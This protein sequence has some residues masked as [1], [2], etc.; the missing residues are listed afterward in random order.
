MRLTD[1]NHVLGALNKIVLL[2][3]F[4]CNVHIA[5]SIF[6]SGKEY[7]YSYDAFSS[8]GVL[9]PSRASSSWGFNGKLK[10]QSEQNVVTMQLES[11]RMNVWNGK[12]DDQGESQYVPEDVTDLL[13]PFQLVYKNGFIEN[14]STEAVSPWSTNIKRSI[15]GILQLDLS[16][17]QKETAFHSNE[18]NHY[19]QCNI[20]Y[21]ANSEEENEL[22]IRKFFD[23]RICIGHPNYFWSNVPKILCPNGD[24]NPL[25]K[26]SE[27]LYKVKVNG[28]INEI[29]F[30]NATGGIYLQPF[31]SFGEAQFH[32]TRQIFKLISVKDTVD[33][34]PVKDL[35]YKV[36]QHELP[37]IDLTQGRGTPDKSIVI[38]SIG[39]L[40]DRLSQRLE[41]PGLDTETD[42]LHNTTIS[43]LLYYLGMLDIVD[44]RNSYTRISGTSYKEET[45]RNMFL[46]ALPQVGTKEAALFILE[47]IQDK[48]VSDMSAIQLLTQLPF[49]IRKPDVQLLVNLQ[50]FLNLPEKISMEVQNTAILA[51]G[52]LIYKTCLLY[53]PYEMLDDY[54]RLYLDKFTETKEY[55]K[56][57]I[58]LEGLANIQLGRVVEFLE[59]IA[60]GSN[61]E[62]RHFRV[63]AAW[64]SLPTAP[65]RPDVIY[66]VYWPILVNRTEH[67]E[68]RIAAL[69]LLIV[70]NPTPSRLITLYWYMQSEPS[71]HLYNYFYTILKSMVHTTH[72]C[73]V[74]I[75]VI[76]AQFTRVLRPPGNKYLITGN[77]LFDYQDTYRKFGAMI[78]GIVIANPLTNIPEVLYV[79]VNT[80]GSG[81]N[82]NHVSLYIKAEGLLHSLSTHQDGPTQVKDILKQ[83]KVDPRQTGPVH[84]EIIARIQE[85]TVLCLHLNETNLIKGFK[86]LSSLPDNVYHIYQNMEFHVNQQRINV[87]LI[88]ESVQVTDLGANVRFAI[89]ATSLFSMRGN[90]TRVSLGRNN[91]IILRT[92]IHK[93]EVIES[94][95]PLIDTWHTAERAYSIHGYLPINITLG[96]EQRPFISYNTPKEHLKMGI[97]AHARTSTNIKGLAIKSK[98]NQICPTCP[99]LYIV[100]KSPEYKSQTVDL[101]QAELAELGG[102]MY[103]KLFDCESVISREKLIRDVL[104][105]HRA[106]YPIWPFLEFAFTALHFLDYCT[107]VPPKGSC[108]VAAYISTLDAQR[109]QVKLEYNKSP[110][111]HLLSLTRRNAES[112]Q[113]LQQWNVAALY[114]ITSWLSDVIKIK[115]TKLV[116]GQEILKF[117]LEAE[118]E[119]PWTWDFLSTKPSD[120][121]RISLNAIW[122]YSDTAKGKCNGSSITLNLL[123]EIS[124][125][126][127]QDSKKVQWP[128]EECRK[129]SEGKRFT[130]YT[131]ACYETSRELSTLRKYQ[132]I[133]QHENVPEQ[134]IRLAWKLRA[135]YDLIGGNSS[136][137]P[138]SK[139][140]VLTATFPNQLDTGELSLNNDAVAIEY[141]YNIIDYFLTRTRIHKYMD[142]SVL[143]AFFG[144]CIVTP[145]YIRSIHNVTYSFHNKREVLLFGQCYHENPKYALTAQNDLYGVN[146]NIYDEI[147]TVRIVPNQTGGTLYNK[148]MY[149]SIPQSFMF[150]SLGTKRVRLDSSTMD[151]IVPNLYLYMHWTQEQILLFFPTYLLEFSCGLCALQT[152][153]TDNLYEKV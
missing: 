108:G 44:L 73:Y 49:H 26:S 34:I 48:K 11:L 141:N 57:M 12:I 101:F 116:P 91:H 133:A 58:W 2:F 27:R 20:E 25:M 119:M 86:Y 142:M 92:S 117:C 129:Q 83:F 82:I 97:T 54:V 77:Y 81:V 100:T 74:H 136:A 87:P 62:S 22:L 150:H 126:Q 110:S 4:F 36:L 76:A 106:N 59:P 78:H 75:G 18:R 41:N 69:T 152:S 6:Q 111:Y 64:A 8:S 21:V 90:F 17:L 51:Y 85:K 148:T 55:E 88:T 98:L 32:F 61:A 38:K 115:A 128:Y 122:G 89:T 93:T 147:D 153:N 66:P 68:M 140:F 143:K 9:L 39:T 130:P 151:V 135:F 103:V 137:Y 145:E 65:L 50:T 52:T 63:L 99:N 70:S 29:L 113:I 121:A 84:L 42:N 139:G 149:I 30:V 35:Y 80:Y 95:N 109:T 71:Q 94:Y 146:V 5:N 7:V 118:K 53:C 105:S 14:F 3:L 79:T 43:V 67:L 1:T 72:P 60:S 104:S 114:E 144:T 28:S 56:K 40:L 134:L 120:P 132:I 16:T 131:D 45:I 19:G 127:L 102:Q 47:L 13:K 138:V 123:G 24:Q 96:F 33:K 124:N 112:S 23:P 107:Y 37:E 46:E 15:A 10:V 125:D 31:Q